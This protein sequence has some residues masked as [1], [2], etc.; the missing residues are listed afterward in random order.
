[1]PNCV[2]LCV[3]E[4]SKLAGIPVPSAVERVNS[5]SLWNNSADCHTLGAFYLLNDVK[6]EAKYCLSSVSLKLHLSKL[7]VRI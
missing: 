6:L 4:R 7:I 1:M 5:C 2:I 3:K